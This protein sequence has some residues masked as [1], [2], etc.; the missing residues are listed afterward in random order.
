MSGIARLWYRLNIWHLTWAL[1][2]IWEREGGHTL[3]WRDAFL[4]RECYRHKLRRL[5]LMRK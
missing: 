3:N 4:E 2:Y 1:Q 5:D